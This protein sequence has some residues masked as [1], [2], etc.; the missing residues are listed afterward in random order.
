MFDFAK[1][2]QYLPLIER[3]INLL[4]DASE[5]NK[6]TLASN[7]EVLESNRQLSEQ[8]AQIKGGTDHA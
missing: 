8:I 5:L 4:Q 3:L 1:F 7:A 2:L 6:K